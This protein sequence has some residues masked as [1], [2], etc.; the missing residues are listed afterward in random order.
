VPEHACDERTDPHVVSVREQ[1]GALGPGVMVVSRKEKALSI[2]RDAF[3]WNVRHPA[4]AGAAVA[5]D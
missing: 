2:E 5:I 1:R 3:H 4:A